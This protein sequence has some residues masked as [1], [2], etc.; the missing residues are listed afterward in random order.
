MVT[1]AGVVTTLA[2]GAGA[3]TAG[4]A[5]GVGTVASFSAPQGVAI[6]PTGTWLAIGDCSNHKI[7]K[8]ILATRQVLTYAGP[9]SGTATSGWADGTGTAVKC[10]YPR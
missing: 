1:P 10:K 3:A 8:I 2:G 6:D 4:S 9:A 7:R 5:D